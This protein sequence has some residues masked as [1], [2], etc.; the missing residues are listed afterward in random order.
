MYLWYEHNY[1]YIQ[2]RKSTKVVVRNVTMIRSKHLI[3]LKG[4]W[5]KVD[6]FC[7]GSR[8]EKLLEVTVSSRITQSSRN[9]WWNTVLVQFLF[10]FSLNRLEPNWSI[11]LS[12]DMKLLRLEIDRVQWYFAVW[13]L[14]NLITWICSIVLNT[15]STLHQIPTSWIFIC[16]CLW[17]FYVEDIGIFGPGKLFQI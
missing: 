17:I 12:I 6:S 16:K 2:W 10:A 15:T 1:S 11:I 8:F 4:A 9:F 13:G 14:R 3:V 7:T 5:Y